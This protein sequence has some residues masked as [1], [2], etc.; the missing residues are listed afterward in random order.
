LVDR[1]GSGAH[2][3]MNYLTF[4]KSAVVLAP[5]WKEQSLEGL[6][7]LAPAEAFPRLRARGICMEEKMFRATCNINT[8]K[9]LIFVLSL[10]LY[11]AGKNREEEGKLLPQDIC[12]RAKGCVEGMI[13]R[14]LEPL[15]KTLPPRA[16]THGER[17][18][19]QHRITGI[20]GEAEK[21]FPALLNAGLPSLEKALEEGHSLHDAGLYALLHLMLA[22]EDSTVIHRGGYEFWSTDYRKA[23]RDV[24][25]RGAPFS[26]KGKKALQELDQHFS[27]LRISPGG[28]ADLLSATLFLHF[29]REAGRK[30]GL[31]RETATVTVS[32]AEN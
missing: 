18:Y 24:L 16:L 11:G 28:A 17:L 4:V 22:A 32:Q 31:S 30:T 19:L 29:C 14:E 12:F 20:R 9:G 5:F 21:G 27:R 15:R 8:H 3:D 6:K 25:R 10:L 2:Q 7:G 1:F 26:E 13:E 23:L